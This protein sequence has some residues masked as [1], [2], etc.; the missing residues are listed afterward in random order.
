MSILKVEG[1]NP[2]IANYLLVANTGGESVRIKIIYTFIDALQFA[3][4]K[5]RR[6]HK[7][8]I[9]ATSILKYT[10]EAARKLKYQHIPVSVITSAHISEMLDIPWKVKPKVFELQE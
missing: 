2:I 1:Y 7:V 8:K 3:L 5:K 4:S 6:T 10:E 9:D